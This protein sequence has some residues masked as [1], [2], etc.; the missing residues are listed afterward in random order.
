VPVRLA[1][2]LN[3]E[4]PAIKD[5]SNMRPASRALV[6]TVTVSGLTP[7]VAYNLYRYDAMT[8]V[9]DAA[10]NANASSAAEKWAIQIDSGSTYSLSENIQSDEVAAYQAVAAS[11][12][13]CRAQTLH[14]PRPTCGLLDESALLTTRRPGHPHPSRTGP[15]HP[16]PYPAYQG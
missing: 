5:G 1:T 14:E 15:A 10:F 12:P 7:G 4:K 13:D 8:S 2:S 9:P 16:A 3:Y 11:D 6:L